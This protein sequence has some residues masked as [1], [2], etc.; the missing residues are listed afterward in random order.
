MTKIECEFL[1]KFKKVILIE[2]ENGKWDYS[3]NSKCGETVY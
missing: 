3:W 2:N 1:L